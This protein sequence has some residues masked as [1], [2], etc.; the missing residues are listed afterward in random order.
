MQDIILRKPGRDDWVDD[1]LQ[2][3]RYNI[4][5]RICRPSDQVT[6]V[7]M[8][9]LQ[10]SALIAQVTSA[11][12]VAAYLVSKDNRHMVEYAFVGED[13]LELGKEN[14]RLSLSIGRMEQMIKGTDCVVVDYITPDPR[15]V[16]PPR[17]VEVGYKNGICVPLRVG[18]K[19]IGFYSL[20]YKNRYSWSQGDRDFLVALGRFLG[21][22]VEHSLALQGAHQASEREREGG[23]DAEIQRDLESILKMLR[24]NET[25]MEKL[26]LRSWDEDALL[27]RYARYRQEH[28]VSEL[29]LRETKILQL[30]A[31]GLSNEEIGRA[32]YVSEGTVK[33][34][35][36]SLLEKL[37]VKNR[38]QAVAYAFR[39]GYVS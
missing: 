21:I 24:A 28:P 3:S 14:R 11:N 37:Q 5:A 15:D 1:A 12:S 26:L 33:K 20:L 32:L 7:N 31:D 16:I 13:S 29:T 25:S 34:Q 35:L 27:K 17:Y 6:N 10:A 9:C 22:A 30:L 19:T 2:R 38:V 39:A 8:L 36:S 23:S 4:L 18:D